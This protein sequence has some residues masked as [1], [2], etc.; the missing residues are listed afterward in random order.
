M[1]RVQLRVQK[2]WFCWNWHLGFCENRQKC[3]QFHTK[4]IRYILSKVWS[5][6]LRIFGCFSKFNPLYCS[7]IFW[8]FSMKGYEATDWSDVNSSLCF[9]LNN[10]NNVVI[11][12]ECLYYTSKRPAHWGSVVFFDDHNIVHC[13]LY[14]F[15][16][17]FFSAAAMMI[18]IRHSF[19]SRTDESFCLYSSNVVTRCCSLVKITRV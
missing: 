19:F 16:P 11:T 5:N 12:V 6:Q 18:S 9:H 3:Y 2:R 13:W 1:L 8:F 14:V 7:T 10:T 4:L 17:P 15:S